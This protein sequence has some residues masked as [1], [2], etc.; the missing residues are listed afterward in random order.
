[1]AKLCRLSTVAPLLL[2]RCI[3][4]LP[5]RGYGSAAA[6][7]VDYDYYDFDEE[8]E[9]DV[10]RKLAMA[11]AVAVA[12]A[13]GCVSGRGVHWVVI[14]EPGAKKHVYA[15][16][17]SEVL[18]VPHISMGTLVRQ[19]LSPHSYLYKQVIFSLFWGCPV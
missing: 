7:Q 16:R 15:E 8:D 9:G 17:L 12:E 18:Q 5:K 14:G 1:M 11:E 10:Y 3:G 2:R 13:E 19:E 6:V 4:V